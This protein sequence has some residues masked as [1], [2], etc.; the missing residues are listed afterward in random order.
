[1]KLL[2]GTTA[3]YI[4]ELNTDHSKNLGPLSEKEVD[5]LDEALNIYE[6]DPKRA[7]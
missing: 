5:L 3:Y 4:D 2:V 7:K 6:T 1:M